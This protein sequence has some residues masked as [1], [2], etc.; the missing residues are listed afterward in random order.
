[1]DSEIFNVMVNKIVKYNKEKLD[2]LCFKQ[3]ILSF[4]QKIKS[5]K[6]EEKIQLLSKNIL[7]MIFSEKNNIDKFMSKDIYGKLR[8]II[9]CE[10]W[11]EIFLETELNIID[12][13]LDYDLG[14]KIWCDNA[15]NT[16]CYSFKHNRFDF[17]NK[18]YF[19]YEKS[20]KNIKNTDYY[21]NFD[22][23]NKISEFSC[24]ENFYFE[25]II[26]FSSYRYNLNNITIILQ[27]FSLHF[28]S[29][30]DESY[31]FTFIMNTVLYCGE[32]NDKIISFLNFIKVFDINKISLKNIYKNID[33]R[34]LQKDRCEGVFQHY[35]DINKQNWEIIKNYIKIIL[36]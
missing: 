32:S 21:F 20:K 6:K 18:Q 25:N 17:L 34:I 23:K 14:V 4:D 19:F 27:S 33:L 10:S 36:A 1:M 9:S 26:N 15:S 7:K 30:H 12:K 31:I 13:F 16:L 8:F 11:Y 29:F 24:N 28:S 2:L 22:R 3:T 5:I 35:G